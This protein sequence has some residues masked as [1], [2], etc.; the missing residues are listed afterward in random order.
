MAKKG[1]NYEKAVELRR[2]FQ[3]VYPYIY[4]DTHVYEVYLDNGYPADNYDL[5]QDFILSQ[6]LADEV[7]E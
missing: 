6:G 1:K 5:I 7:V 3:S 2:K 4:A